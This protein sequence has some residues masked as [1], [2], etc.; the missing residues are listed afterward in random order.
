MLPK[1]RSRGSFFWTAFGGMNPKTCSRPATACLAAFV[2]LAWLIFAFH[3]AHYL[4]HNC[5]NPAFKMDFT[6]RHWHQKLL[7]QHPGKAACSAAR[8]G[9]GLRLSERHTK[10]KTSL[11]RLFARLLGN[12]S[13]QL[14]TVSQVLRPSP[15]VP[16]C[17]SAPQSHWPRQ[18]KQG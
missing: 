16:H 11:E 8:C 17:A 14:Q 5:F 6:V 7:S 12:L 3:S 18:R 4:E 10:S 9:I 2:R 15:P 1:R 13:R